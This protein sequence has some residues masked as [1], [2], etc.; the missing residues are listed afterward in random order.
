MFLKDA[1]TRSSRV[2]DFCPFPFSLLLLKVSNNLNLS[3]LFLRTALAKIPLHRQRRPRPFFD[4]AVDETAPADRPVGVGEEDVAL[5]GAQ[6]G[7][8]FGDE[9]GGGEEPCAFG[10]LVVGPVVEDLRLSL[11]KGSDVIV[12][13]FQEDLPD[14]GCPRRPCSVLLFWSLR[15]PFRV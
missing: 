2:V 3:F 1:S 14:G 5:A 13:L 10:E 12:G 9:A 15:C 7:E 6:V 8:G 4:R 11:A